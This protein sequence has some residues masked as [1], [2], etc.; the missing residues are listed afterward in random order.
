MERKKTFEKAVKENVK[1]GSLVVTTKGINS[2]K[3]EYTTPPNDGDKSYEDSDFSRSWGLSLLAKPINEDEDYMI[4]FISESGQELTSMDKGKTPSDAEAKFGKALS[5]ITGFK[6]VRDEANKKM[7]YGI[8]GY[9]MSG[10]DIINLC[11]NMA[12]HYRIKDQLKIRGTLAFFYGA[13]GGGR[14]NAGSINWAGWNSGASKSREQYV[15]PSPTTLLSPTEQKNMTK[16]ES[17]LLDQLE[18]KAIKKLN[19]LLKI[20]TANKDRPKALGALIIEPIQGSR[21]VRFYRPKFLEYLSDW[22]MKKDVLLIADEILTG[23]GRTGKYWSYEHYEGFRPDL[24]AFGKG[25]QIAGVAKT[26]FAEKKDGARTMTQYTPGLVTNKAPATLLLKGARV[27]NVITEKTLSE[28][29]E[30]GQLLLKLIRKYQLENLGLENEATGVGFM[31]GAI[32]PDVEGYNTIREDAPQNYD[33]Y[34]SFRQRLMPPLDIDPNILYSY[35]K[36]LVE[37]EL[38]NDHFPYEHYNNTLKEQHLKSFD[39]NPK[40]FTQHESEVSKWYQNKNGKI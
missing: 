39:I 33:G 21:G 7:D 30:R 8:L 32:V 34:L 3:K 18:F 10:S 5:Y 9:A 31:I 16:V 4:N 1:T 22:C 2:I 23:G 14:G 20:D 6:P 37:T 15:L 13:Y 38:K 29:V 17:E 19:E 40:W 36:T 28:V 26:A 27:L 24:V 35:F 25:L 12:H 11:F